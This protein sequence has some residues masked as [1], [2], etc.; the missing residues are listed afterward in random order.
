MN[1]SS[2]VATLMATLTV[3]GKLSL[4]N[5][6]LKF[7][8]NSSTVSKTLNALGDVSVEASAGI[9][10]GTGNARHEFNLS[11]DL[12]TDG[13]CSFTNRTTANYGAEATDGI[14]D[15]N[16]VNDYEDQVVRLMGPQSSIE[17]KSTRVLT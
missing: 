1:T 2:S 16:I 5:G 17:L 15:L 4:F 9:Q 14:V 7:N 3:N 12:I 11:G 13:T 8:D 10:V 6:I